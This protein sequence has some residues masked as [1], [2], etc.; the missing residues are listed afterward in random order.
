MP[1]KV[2]LEDRKENRI[3]STAEFD[4]VSEASR[5]VKALLIESLMEPALH[6]YNI[7]ISHEEE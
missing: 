6:K 7:I 4:N 1:V 3:A 5:Y 2:I